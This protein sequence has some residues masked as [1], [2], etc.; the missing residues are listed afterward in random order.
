MHIIQQKLLRLA[1]TY[2]LGDMS[3]RDIGKII[4]D[5]HPQLV[6]HHLEQLKKRKLISWDKSKKVIVKIS[7]GPISNSDFVT[8]PVLG[9]AN[10]GDATIFAD[11][12]I[13]GHIKVSTKLV[14]NKRG[15]F[16]IKAVGSSMNKANIDGKNIEEND[17]VIVDPKDINIRNN[18]Y[19][20]SIIDDVANIKKITFDPDHDQIVL[21]SESSNTYPPIYLHSSE[22][23]KY[24]VN[25]KVVQV[26]KKSRE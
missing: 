15:I 23:G 21:V 26:I 16:A 1:D 6:K 24:L 18:D 14:K 7:S 11:E 4:G 5:V 9:S 25:G 20:L 10:C 2:N 8:I 19:V 22:A 13:E 3:F 12:R 17:Y